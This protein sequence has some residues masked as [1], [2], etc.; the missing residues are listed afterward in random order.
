MD[1]CPSF[2][3]LFNL[4][5]KQGDQLYLTNVTYNNAPVDMKILHLDKNYLIVD[6]TALGSSPKTPSP[7]GNGSCVS[8]NGGSSLWLPS[9]P[10][11]PFVIS[12][13]NRF[14]SFGCSMGVFA[15]AELVH[16]AS[17]SEPDV[18]R[19]EL[20]GCAVLCPSPKCDGHTC[21][22]ANLSQGTSFRGVFYEVTPS[23]IITNSPFDA[24]A[25]CQSLYATVF[26]PNYSDFSNKTYGIKLKWALPSNLT[27]SALK[28]TSDY[29]CSNNSD[30]TIVREVPGYYCFCLDG[31]EGDG[32]SEGLG[33][34]DIDE[35]KPPSSNDCIPGKS[36][37][38]DI[39]GGYK[40]KCNSRFHVGDGL[41]SG[42][43]CSL[44]PSLRI[45]LAIVGAVIFVGLLLGGVVIFAIWWRRR[46]KRKYFL[47][48]GGLQL[49]DM[50]VKAGG[51]W[52][53]RRLFTAHELQEATENYADHM[54][55]GMGGFGTVFK[56]VLSDGRPVAIKKANRAE[57]GNE[58]FLNELQIL[59]HINHRNIVRLLGC[60]M[61]IATPL[62]VYEYVSHGNVRENLDEG[63]TD[64]MSWEQR[65]K[66]A[67]QSAE[68]LAY[69]HAA[70]FP[71]ILHRDV[72]SANVLLDDNLD[73]KVAD[74]GASRLVPDGVQHVS[75]AVQGTIGYLD[76]EYFQTL[77]LTDKSDVYSLGVMLVELISGLK[78]VDS[79][80][81]EPEFTNLALLFINHMQEARGEDLID[82]RLVEPSTLSN[83]K[84]LDVMMVQVR[85]SIMA[86]ADLAHQCL[87]LH[88]DERPSMSLL[89][90]ELRRI[91]HALRDGHYDKDTV[92]DYQRRPLIEHG[93]AGAAISQDAEFFVKSTS[94]TISISNLQAPSMPR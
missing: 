88:G 92:N 16:N 29:A 17:T 54:K 84:S 24:N 61:E 80:T 7:N 49:Q 72:K 35:C 4:H 65:L 19:V 59:M 69:L 60:C 9:L 90:D 34:G 30:S 21:C 83:D 86:V 15:G 6:A 64:V 77:Q 18:S 44:S 43:G 63:G 13:D 3:H 23:S 52:D 40:C 76:P 12:D 27:K 28:R 68:A 58:E 91:A 56:G 25:E 47:Q 20:G 2:S 53:Q 57:G 71:P 55:L 39:E 5:C 10:S 42:N 26:H 31:F 85:S 45:T 37:C 75:T 73:A 74:F 11:G 41:R 50:I 22:V 82:P 32:Y 93:E 46:T 38:H 51:Q 62:L 1:N 8:A 67:R 89:A 36:T 87:A 14:G 66:V 33:C 78:P 81:R 94:S 70:A 79:R 48:N